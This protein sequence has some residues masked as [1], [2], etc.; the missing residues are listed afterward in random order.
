MRTMKAI[1]S[2]PMTEATFQRLYAALERVYPG[3]VWRVVEACPM[4]V[5]NEEDAL[6][7]IQRIEEANEGKAIGSAN[8]SSSSSE[9]RATGGRSL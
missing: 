5:D 2:T 4:A 3:K 6:R 7:T 8:N 1:N 9:M